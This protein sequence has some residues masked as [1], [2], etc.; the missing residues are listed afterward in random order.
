MSRDSEALA[1]WAHMALPEQWVPEKAL[2]K[3]GERKGFLSPS[4][5]WDFFLKCVR[6]CV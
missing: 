4:F 2:G 6:A 3:Q 5:L 1:A